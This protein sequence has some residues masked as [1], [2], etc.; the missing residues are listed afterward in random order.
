ML[1]IRKM[2][3]M[4]LSAW[5]FF[6]VFRCNLCFFIPHVKVYEAVVLAARGN[7]AFPAVG[8]CVPDQV[9]SLVCDSSRGVLKPGRCS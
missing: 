2:D 6:S 5:P 4:D 8:A 1:C 7:M 3:L 9:L